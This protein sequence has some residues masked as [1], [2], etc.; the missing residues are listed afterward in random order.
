[1]KRKQK[2]IFRLVKEEKGFNYGYPHRNHRS[3]KNE[4]KRVKL[5]SKLYKIRKEKIN[6][7]REK[8]LSEF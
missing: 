5:K 4:S 2:K 6:K 3:K 7:M 8:E 1:M